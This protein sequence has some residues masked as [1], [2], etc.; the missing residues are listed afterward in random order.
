MNFLNIVLLARMS[1]IIY[2][3]VYDNI[4][5]LE[6]IDEIGQFSLLLISKILQSYLINKKYYQC[7]QIMV[8]FQMFGF[9]YRTSDYQSFY[10]DLSIED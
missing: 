8:C 1:Q 2:I 9:L 6:I 4:S 3:V 7:S 5:T 10:H